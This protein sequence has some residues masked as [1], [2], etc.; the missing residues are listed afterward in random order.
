MRQSAAAAAKDVR[1]SNRWGRPADRSE[2]DKALL[3]E[4]DVEAAWQEA[5][6]GGCDDSLWMEL[7][8]RR[9][10]GHPEDVLPI[11][12][13]QIEHLI[14]VKKN[15]TYADAVALLHRVKK[16]LDRLDRGS[17]SA[18]YL[19]AVRAAHKPKRNLMKLLD[20]ARW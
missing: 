19:A 16:L 12:Q 18:A 5:S 17:E 2:L 15:H 4:G 20:E 10:A 6:A 14:N 8:A 3:W 11:Y 13:R 7:A 9:E 1:E